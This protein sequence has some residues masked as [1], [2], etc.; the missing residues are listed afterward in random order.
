MKYIL[1]VTGFQIM[2]QSKYASNK[3]TTNFARIAR[4]IL[5]PCTDV[6]RDVLKK[7]ICPSDLPRLVRT[8]LTK[9]KKCQITKEQENLI[10]KANYSDF[11]V[12]LL[13]FLLRNISNIPQHTNQWGNTPRPGDNSVS[14]N[15]E[16]IRL[17]RNEFGHSSDFSISENDFKN[18]WQEIFDIVRNLE[19]YVGSATNCQKAVDS[20]KTCS[21]DPDQSIKY[22]KKL[23]DLNKKI[24]DISG[25]LF[26]LNMFTAQ[27]SRKLPLKMTRAI[28]LTIS[29]DFDRRSREYSKNDYSLEC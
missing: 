23:I 2:A 28:L 9:Q 16:M 25:I 15:I 10:N 17:I 4:L 1:Y 6:L 29:L 19:G 13:Y 8:Y 24:N 3:E 21:M 14:A 18:K 11:D 7:E 20:I 27:F 5:G 22:T 12:T 26:A